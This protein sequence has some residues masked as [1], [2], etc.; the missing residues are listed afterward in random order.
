MKRKY[1][2]P[3]WELVELMECPRQPDGNLTIFGTFMRTMIPVVPVPKKSNWRRRRKKIVYGQSLNIRFANNKKS[4]PHNFVEIPLKWQWTSKNEE[5]KKTRRNEKG[6]PKQKSNNDMC[7]MKSI[8][9][10]DTWFYCISNGLMWFMI[11]VICIGGNATHHNRG[12]ESAMCA[13]IHTLYEH[14]IQ[15]Y[16]YERRRCSNCHMHKSITNGFV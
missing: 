6:S 9:A 11:R 7:N 10:A 8:V 4:S 5:K 14:L 13:H 12:E 15:S 2:H 3:F 16:I 1:A